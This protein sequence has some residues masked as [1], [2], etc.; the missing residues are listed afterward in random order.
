MMLAN[1]IKISVFS[2]PEEDF[3]KMKDSLL[4]FFP[5]NLKEEKIPIKEIVAKGFDDKK[6]RILEVLLK[7]A[8]HT[9]ALI[10]KFQE[11]FSQEQKNKLLEEENRIDDNCDFYFRLNKKDFLEEKYELT[12]SGDC[13]HIKINVASFPKKKEAA[14]KVLEKI[15][16]TK[17]ETKD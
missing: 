15:F 12:D 3:E 5:F 17:K 2:K 4:N 1:S 13:F 16:K 9:N 10:K 6:I 7:K 14:R 8:T 11:I